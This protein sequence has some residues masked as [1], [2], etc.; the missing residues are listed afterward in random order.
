MIKLNQ[1]GDTIIEVL[2]SIAILSMVLSV[3]YSLSNRSA[4]TTRQAQ[5]RAEALKL[6]EGQMER[7]RVYIGSGR[8]WADNSCLDNNNNLITPC[9]TTFGSPAPGRYTITISRIATDTY[10]ARTT[11]DSAS[12]SGQDNLSLSSRLSR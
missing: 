11:W 6:T 7:L 3:A 12:G 10:R 2:L 8:P 5:E 9:S 4:Q 1:S